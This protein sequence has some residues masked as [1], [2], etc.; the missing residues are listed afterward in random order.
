MGDAGSFGISASVLSMD[1]MEVTTETAPEGTG[2]FFDATDLMI[3]VSYARKLTSDFQTGLTL[4]YIEQR[5][6]NEKASGF[7]IDIGTQ[8]RLG[9][10]D[11]TIGMSMT[12]FGSDLKYSGRDLNVRYDQNSQVSYNRYTP[13]DMATE[14]YPLPLHFQVGLSMT[15]IT[16]D[17]MSMLIAVDVTHPNDNDEHV[18][19]GS[20]IKLLD[21][22]FVRG[23]YRFGYD[24]ERA[25]LGMGLDIPLEGTSIRFDYAYAVYDLLPNINRFS[26]GIVF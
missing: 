6:W 2:E 23:G 22:L 4:K 25:T 19:L 21:R 10:R 8:Y 1:K 12:N 5:M 14:D 26:L 15:A 9:F 11:L 18:N 13:A 7:A 16:T 20:E 24:T 17:A 3:G